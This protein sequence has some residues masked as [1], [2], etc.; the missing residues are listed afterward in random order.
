[1]R[2]TFPSGAMVAVCRPALSYTKAVVPVA[3]LTFH[4]RF[5]SELFA[6][7]HP[8]E[9]GRAEWRPRTL[10]GRNEE[11]NQSKVCASEHEDS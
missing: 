8:A 4:R 1:V 9:S 2:E 5:S 10:F 7:Q 6:K 3:M 11:V